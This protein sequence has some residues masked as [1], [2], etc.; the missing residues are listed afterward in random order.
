MKLEEI[1]AGA[2]AFSLS[3]ILTRAM[4]TRLVKRTNSIIGEE[5]VFIQYI[6]VLHN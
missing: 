4:G 3:C 5:H 6:Y 2:R 1:L